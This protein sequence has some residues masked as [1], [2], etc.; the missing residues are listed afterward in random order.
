MRVS[1]AL[2]CWR[3]AELELQV[4]VDGGADEAVA[5]KRAEALFAKA[6]YHDAYA[7]AIASFDVNV[8]AGGG[9]GA[10]AAGAARVGIAA[11]RHDHSAAI[12]RASQRAALTRSLG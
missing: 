2:A 9:V 10:A 5:A 8:D 11:E 6:R 4:L 7:A 12:E 3:R 1:D